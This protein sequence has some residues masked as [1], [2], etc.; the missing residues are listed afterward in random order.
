[1]FFSIK[2]LAVIQ[3]CA[4]VPT[5]QVYWCFILISSVSPCSCTSSDSTCDCHCLFQPFHVAHLQTLVSWIN[6]GRYFSVIYT[7][8]YAM[9]FDVLSHFLNIT[10]CISNCVRRRLGCYTKS[11]V[12]LFSCIKE[13]QCTHGNILHMCVSEI[14][15]CC[16][17]GL[18]KYPMVYIMIIC[19]YNFSNE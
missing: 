3:Q 10:V 8:C 14:S 6:K 11:L 12:G 7:V 13:E 1:M 2:I 18:L 4:I 5:L 16:S 15:S 17:Q 9:L 19:L